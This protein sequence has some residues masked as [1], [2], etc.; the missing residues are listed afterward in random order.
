M[1]SIIE[2]DIQLLHYHT[3]SHN[4]IPLP[5]CSHLFS[6]GSLLPL[7]FG[8]SKLDLNLPHPHLIII[9]GDGTVLKKGEIGKRGGWFKKGGTI[10]ISELW[11]KETQKYLIMFVNDRYSINDVFNRFFFIY[12]FSSYAQ[13]QLITRKLKK[14]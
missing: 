6:F 9:W 2:G 1:S 12:L 3:R 7:L 14:W 11:N 4:W 10:P 13:T 5:S 8:R